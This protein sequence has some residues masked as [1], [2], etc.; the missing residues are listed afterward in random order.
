[1]TKGQKWPS[2]PSP[3]R[4]I[5]LGDSLLKGGFVPFHDWFCSRLTSFLLVL[6]LPPSV[7]YLCAV[8]PHPMLLDFR[9]E[10]YVQ[11]RKKNRHTELR[12]V[13]GD[14]FLSRSR[15]YGGTL[16]KRREVNKRMSLVSH[17]PNKQNMEKQ[18]FFLRLVTQT[19]LECRGSEV[20]FDAD[21]VAQQKRRMLGLPHELP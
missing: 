1:M 4:P 21:R 18:L 9:L 6:L 13:R 7:T 2:T 8:C 19:R 20:C 3:R 10:N 15:S 5:S 14:V 16:R 12:G 17:I 11:K